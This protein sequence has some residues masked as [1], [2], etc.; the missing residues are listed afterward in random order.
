MTEPASIRYKNPGAM[1]GRTGPRTSSLPTASTN[2]A[3]PLKWGSKTTFYLS[4]GLGQGNN[5]AVFDTYVQGICA[6]LD[7]WRASKNYAGKTL[8]AALYTWSGG[9]NTESYISFVTARVPG[10]TRNTVMDDTFWRGSMCVPF[11]KAQAWHEAGKQYPAPD[12]DWIE[13]QRRVLG[14]IA[15]VPPVAPAKP[16]APT[17]APKPVPVQPPASTPSAPMPAAHQSGIAAAIIATIAAIFVWGQNHPG[18]VLCGVI[19]AAVVITLIVRHHLK[20]D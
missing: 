11:L 4:D 15:A 13:A 5:I 10:I 12:G 16:S 8:A 18:E 2:S 9:N 19:G 20:K 7:L 6:Q 1:W 17:P 3:I 14:G